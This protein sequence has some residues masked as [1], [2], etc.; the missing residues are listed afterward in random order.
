MTG[1][2]RKP[3]S[4]GLPNTL[5]PFSRRDV[6]LVKPDGGSL[7]QIVDSNQACWWM[8]FGVNSRGCIIGYYAQ[9]SPKNQYGS[10]EPQEDFCQHYSKQEVIKISQYAIMNE[11]QHLK[12]TI[13]QEFLRYFYI[14]KHYH[15]CLVQKCTMVTLASIKC[16][17]T[18]HQA[19]KT[20]VTWQ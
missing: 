1:S 12:L 3:P 16:E 13:S 19:N 14:L 6:Y 2:L 17:Y 4:N 10:D 15:E 8:T 5:L 20:T 18:D 7:G 11:N 9:M